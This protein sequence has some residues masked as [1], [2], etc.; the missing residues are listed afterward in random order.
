GFFNLIVGCVR[1]FQRCQRCVAMLLRTV[2]T[3][4]LRTMSSQCCCDAAVLGADWCR[5]GERIW[6]FFFLSFRSEEVVVS[7]IYGQVL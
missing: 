7:S 1:S 6:G 2:P 5:H 3:M 4:L